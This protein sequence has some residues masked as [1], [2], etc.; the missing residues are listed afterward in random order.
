MFSQGGGYKSAEFGYKINLSKQI[1]RITELF[2]QKIDERHEDIALSQKLAVNVQLT[3]VNI[4][5][6]MLQPYL[7]DAYKN[8]MKTLE[9]KY[10]M[11][12]K[13]KNVQWKNINE[14]QDFIEEKFGLLME[15]MNR[16]RMLM[17]ESVEEIE[18]GLSEEA[19]AAGGGENA[20]EG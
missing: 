17:E 19:S 13:E 7:D 15:L 3:A 5:E 12:K 11:D 20:A 4:L 6:R 10:D 14:K 1:D 16:K 18:E 2:S 8:G 9:K